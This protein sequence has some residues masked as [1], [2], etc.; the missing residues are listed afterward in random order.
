MDRYF[1]WMPDGWP[2]VATIPWL[3]P[4]TRCI[5]WLGHDQPYAIGRIEP[6]LLAKL[7][8]YT[9]YSIYHYRTAQPSYCPL[10]AGEPTDQHGNIDQ[11]AIGLGTAELRIIGADQQ[12]YAVPNNLVHLIQIHRYQP[13]H[14]FLAAVASGLAPDSVAY[15]TQLQAIL[16][17]RERAAL[18]WYPQAKALTAEIE[19]SINQLVQAKPAFMSILA[20]ISRKYQREG[21]FV[22]ANLLQPPY[23]PLLIGLLYQ[24]QMGD[25]TDLAV[26][27]WL[28]RR[29]LLPINWLMLA[30]QVY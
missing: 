30:H 22:L 17:E 4:T 28:N 27:Q 21:A 18:A 16:T 1:P 2:Y 24:W 8:A 11:A 26:L 20:D 25:L 15:Q 14:H 29:N 7:Q 5:G 9:P 10:C 12:C 6:Q 23:A 13:P 3:E 19:S